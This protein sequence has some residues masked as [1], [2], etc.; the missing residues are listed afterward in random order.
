[1]STESENTRQANIKRMKFQTNKML[2]ELL[3]QSQIS[4]S[5]NDSQRNNPAA[6][7]DHSFDI[8]MEGVSDCDPNEEHDWKKKTF[9]MD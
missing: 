3:K 2:S 7:Y 9:I 4:G 8:N 1:M 5:V 6:R